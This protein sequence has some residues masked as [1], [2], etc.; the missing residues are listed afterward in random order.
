MPITRPGSVSKTST[1]SI[2]ATAATKSGRAAMPSRLSTHDDTP[3]PPERGDVDQL[4]HGRDDDGGERRLGQLLE[5]AGEEEQRH[6]GQPG[7]DQPGHLTL[8]TG[9]AVDGGLRE[10]AVDDHAARQARTEVGG[11]RGRA[12]RRWRRSRSDA[13]RRRSW[14]LPGPP[15]SRSARRPQRCRQAPGTPWHGCP[16]GR[17][18]AGRRRCSRRSPRRA[19]PGRTRRPRRRRTRP[20]RASPGSSAGSAGIRPR[21]RTTPTPTNS[22]RHCVS[23]RFR[24]RSQIFSK[25]SPLP[26]STPNSLGSWPAMIVSAS[27]MMKPLSTGSEMKLATKP[28]RS[29]PA[30]AAID[31]RCDRERRSQGDELAAPGRGELRHDGRRERRRGRHRAGDEVPRAAEDGVQDQRAG[32]RVETDDGRRARDRRVRER[33]R[34]E[35]GPHGQTGDRVAAQPLRAVAAQRSERPE[36]HRGHRR[37]LP[38]SRPHPRGV[39]A[40]Q[41]WV[42]APVSAAGAVSV[43]VSVTVS[44]SVE[45]SVLAS[46]AVPDSHGR[47]RRRRAG[48]TA[49]FG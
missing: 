34:H 20:Q 46:G 2:A 14:P 28:S 23:P 45:T 25:K 19:R 39:N 7:H 48:I 37:R 10:A 35:H 41:P 11:A 13:G 9:A 30:I 47:H 33:F 36:R 17:A 44:V 22:V 24:M 4:E 49:G 15:Q 40:S 43:T 32:R 21:S 26:F 42:V 6:D 16:E 18:T 8:G 1:P 12:A 31:A 27:P 29:R 5:Q 38:T 3:E